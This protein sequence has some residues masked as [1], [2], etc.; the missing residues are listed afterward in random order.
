MQIEAI[1]VVVS[2]VSE[3][4]VVSEIQVKPELTDGLRGVDG[5]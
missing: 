2:P 4:A 1:G 5:G 3:G